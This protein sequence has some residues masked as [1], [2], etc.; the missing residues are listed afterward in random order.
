MTIMKDEGSCIIFKYYSIV[1]VTDYEQD[2]KEK[3]KAKVSGIFRAISI[4]SDNFIALY[5]T[6]V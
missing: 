2:T 5:E 6:G 3:G 1:D 4:T